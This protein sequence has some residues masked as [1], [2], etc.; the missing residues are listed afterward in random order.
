VIEIRDANVRTKLNAPGSL[1]ALQRDGAKVRTK[2]N[3]MPPADRAD[4]FM[5]IDRARADLGASMGRLCVEACVSSQHYERLRRAQG[6]GV[7]ARLITT[8][9][10]A[11][12]TLHAGEIRNVAAHFEPRLIAAAYRGCL[13]AALEAFAPD[14]TAAEALRLLARRGEYPGDGL[15]RKASQARRYALYLASTELGLRGSHLALVTGLTPAA[16]SISLGKVE[17]R[18]D[19]PD[20]ERAMQVAAAA[21][22]RSE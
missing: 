12:R 19:E 15:W 5:Q 13:A 7:T 2:L 16:V 9:H 17:D 1:R 10:R 8:L 14:M 18:M 3:A 6:R 20:F 21:L 11:L 22:G 4:L